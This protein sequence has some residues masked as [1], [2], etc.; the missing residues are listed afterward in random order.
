MNQLERDIE[1]ARRNLVEHH[2]RE[3][4][5]LDRIVAEASKSTNAFAAE[6][7]RQEREA[8]QARERV[9]QAR[10]QAREDAERYALARRLLAESLI[11]DFGPDV[12]LRYATHAPSYPDN[13]RFHALLKERCAAPAVD[14]SFEDV[15][16]LCSWLNAQPPDACVAALAPTAA[17][18]DD[19][20]DDAV[21][22]EAAYGLGDGHA[23]PAWDTGVFRVTFSNPTFGPHY[24]QRI[25]ERAQA[26][27]DARGMVLFPIYAAVK[28]VQRALWV[29]AEVCRDLPDAPPLPVTEQ[30]VTDWLRGLHG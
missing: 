1:Q 27:C 10:E 30:A 9:R 18:A 24:W 11:F 13:P 28:M 14:L 26:I 5:R 15:G 21:L 6:Q 8:E 17:D 19:L 7:E 3:K 2:R 12:R 22:A 16:P 4:E 29:W 20:E 25:A 23:L